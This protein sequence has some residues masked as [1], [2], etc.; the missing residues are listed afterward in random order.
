MANFTLSD[1]EAN[2]LLALFSNAPALARFINQANVDGVEFN[3]YLKRKRTLPSSS[4][5]SRKMKMHPGDETRQLPIAREDEIIALFQDMKTKLPNDLATPR[6]EA[7][8]L[9]KDTQTIAEMRM[10]VVE[11]QLGRHIEYM[12]AAWPDFVEARSLVTE[13]AKVLSS[14]ESSGPVTSDGRAIEREVRDRQVLVD[15]FVREASP[16]LERNFNHRKSAS[17]FIQNPTTVKFLHTSAT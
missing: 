17:D 8:K 7:I 11:V 12:R 5:T 6:E 15:E 3:Q 4:I 10:G 1:K 13:A 9:A 16:F 14:L 2:Q